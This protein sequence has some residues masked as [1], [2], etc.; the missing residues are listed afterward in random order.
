VA[1]GSLA[2][3]YSEQYH[4]TAEDI[5]RNRIWANMLAHIISVYTGAYRADDSK[6]VGGPASS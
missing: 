6:A 5:D 4:A 1:I 2:C 3:H